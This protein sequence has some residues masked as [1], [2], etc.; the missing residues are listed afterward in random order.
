MNKQTAY[1]VCKINCDYNL[2]ANYK[3]QSNSFLVS[4]IFKDFRSYGNLASFRS[5]ASFRDY[6][7]L[8]RLQNL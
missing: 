7:K 6:L 3:S 8:Q 1:T 5:F 4:E 2:Y